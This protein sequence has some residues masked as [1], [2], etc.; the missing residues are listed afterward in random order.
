MRLIHEAS[1]VAADPCVATI[2]F[3]DG[4]HR[5][6]RCLLEQVRDVA[7]ARHLRS[8]LITFPVHPRK[9]MGKAE[10]LELLTTFDE[11]LALLE[12][13][14]IDC[15]LLLD[16]TPELARL[17]AREFMQ[18]LSERFRVECLVIGY[19]HRFG[20]NRSESFDDY[21]AY[22]RSMGMEVV[23]ACAERV[24]WDGSGEERAV[25]SSVVRRLLHKGEVAEAARCLGYRYFL[26]GT[27]VKGN[28]LGRTIGFPTANLA[29][30]CPDKL[31]PANGVYAVWVEWDEKTCKGMLNIGQRP[32]LGSGLQ[33]TIEVHILGFDGDIYGETLC[34]RFVE[35]MRSEQKF[36]GINDLAVQLA[37]DAVAV[38]AALGWQDSGL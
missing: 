19:D 24:D 38:E 23:R 32:T 21:L 29:V 14:G 11:K 25:S 9:V 7:A 26:S 6:H 13:T 15:C 8:A 16:F 31:V 10:E 1:P 37:K 34:L 2:G 30:N 18:L 17:T 4:V 27:V 36:N 33:R 12:R 3:F 35:R 5:G 28:Q 20:H 22:G